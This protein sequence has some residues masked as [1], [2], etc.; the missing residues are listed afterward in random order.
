MTIITPHSQTSTN[1]WIV[2]S[3]VSVNAKRG[4]EQDG[5]MCNLCWVIKNYDEESSRYLGIGLVCGS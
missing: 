2:Q 5:Q 4:T 3:L 1:Q